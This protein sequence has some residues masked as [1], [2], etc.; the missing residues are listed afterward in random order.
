MRYLFLLALCLEPLC[1]RGEPV[2]ILGAV[3][4][5]IVALQDALQNHQQPVVEGIPCDTGTLGRHDVVLALTGVGKTNSAMVTTALL[6]HFH[7]SVALMTGTAARIRTSI[8][9]GDVIIATTTSFHDAGSLTSTGMVQGKL[10]DQGHLTTTLW[11]S[12]TRE[13]ANPFV[14]PDTPELIDL[15]EK[16]AAGYKPPDVQLDGATYQPV[17]RKGTITSGDLSGVTEAKI[18]DIR[19]KIDPDLMEMESA[20]FAQVCQFYHVPHLVIRSGSN[21]AEERNNDDYLRLSPIAA[22]Q[23]ALF[24][25]AIANALP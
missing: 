13:K 8:R 15:A 6:T 7:P 18:A 19:A 1:G 10:D 11:F 2:L 25:L 24:T 20:A 4:Q 3:P 21:I 9:T 5:E 14:F 17:I 22:R 16:V 12:P 23:A